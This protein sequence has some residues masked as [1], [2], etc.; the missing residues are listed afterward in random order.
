MAQWSEEHVRQMLSDRHW[1]KAEKKI[2]HGIQF[3]LVDDST[4]VNWFHT[5]RIHVQGKA[6]GALKESAELLFVGTP[7]VNVSDN[8]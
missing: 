3:S 6:T 7:V 2:Q 4:M 5:G 8:S 1:L